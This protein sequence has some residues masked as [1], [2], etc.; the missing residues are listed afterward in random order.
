MQLIS[1]LSTGS[2]PFSMISTVLHD[3]GMWDPTFFL[4]K[5]LP[6]CVCCLIIRIGWAFWLR[7]CQGKLLVKVL[8][9]SAVYLSMWPIFR[10]AEMDAI[11]SLTFVDFSQTPCDWN[12]SYVQGYFLLALSSLRT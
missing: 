11:T 10:L 12:F 9:F 3:L 6:L 1:D 4:L 7:V 8:S 2:D 5:Y